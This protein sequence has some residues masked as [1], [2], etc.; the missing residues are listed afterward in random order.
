MEAVENRENKLGTEPVKKLIAKFAITS[1][2]SMLVSSLYNIVDQIFIGQGVGLLGNAATNVA[3]PV[4]IACTAA[5]LLLGIG[6]ASNYNLES[7]AG[8]EKEACKIAGT[9]LCLLGVC[10]LLIAA[11]V[12]IF[13]E[14][15]LHLFG[16]T[17]EVL[18]F[19]KDYTGI[20]ALGVPFLVLTTGGNHLVRA[21][22]SPAYSMI[23]MLTGAILNTIL[24]PLFI[25]SFGWGIK[26]AAWATVIGQVISGL[27]VI[28]YFCHFR[29]MDLRREMLRPDFK[30][31]RKIVSLGMAS[32]INQ[33]AMGIVQVTM[34]N[35]LRIY[36]A[37]SVYGAEIP[38]ACAGVISKV[39]MVF[40]AIC[41]GIS[42]GCQP[43]IGYNY[44]AKNYARVKET[45]RTAVTLSLMIGAIF[46]L[47]FQVF[48]RQI[49]QIFGNGSEN[50]FRF[51]ERY[52]RI[53]MFFTFLNG[54]HPFVSG[55]F[56]SIGKA[57]LGAIVSLT[58]Q[59][60]FLLPLIVI[61]PIF[62]GIDGVMYA[63]P[64]A[65]GAAAFTAIG[66]G[67]RELQKMRTA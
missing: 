65:D 59:V 64:I 66:L 41:I 6:S 52:F 58:R 48:P 50:Y 3:F 8:N 43:I 19:A 40:M 9:G 11:V 32:C 20:T 62:L 61:F 46:F 67:I 2:I 44:G 22:K 63:G 30:C 17:S 49:I 36:G 35:V 29:E 5:A 27:M 14:P 37:K 24:D 25:F 7:G 23:C 60:L 55:F 15:L 4:T 33:V 51:A 45:V 13:L 47:C 16:A 10:G 26:G 57:K 56:T 12:L 18:P 38:L 53:Y 31:F 39:N 34:N 54:I 21:D 42:Q 1:I 28:L